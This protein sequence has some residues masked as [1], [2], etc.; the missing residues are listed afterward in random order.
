MT[1]CIPATCWKEVCTTVFSKQKIRGENLVFSF[2]KDDWKTVSTLICFLKH[3]N[4]KHSSH[5]CIQNGSKTFLILIGFFKTFES[6]IVGLGGPVRQMGGPGPPRPAHDAGSGCVHG[7][8]KAFDPINTKLANKL[9]NQKR[10]LG[11]FN[12]QQ[13]SVMM[14]VCISYL[15]HRQC[16]ITVRETCSLTF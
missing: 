12:L 4:Q 16:S 7:H 9:Y 8:L 5:T 3:F 14:T 6:K 10:M 15:L 1:W 2:Q 11:S 13:I